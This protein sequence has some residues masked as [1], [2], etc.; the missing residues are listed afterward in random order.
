[1]NLN[2]T[3][4]VFVRAPRYVLGEITR[5]HDEIDG[6]AEFVDEARMVPDADLWGWGE[7]HQT[8]L[9][10]AELAVEAGSR[11]LAAAAVEPG[12]VDALVLC[13][14]R[15]PAEIAQHGELIAT[16]L[17]GLELGPVP[18]TGVTLNRC[19]NL[20]VGLRVAAA[21]V[22]AGQ[23]RT[24]LVITT[25]RVAEE[26]ERLTEFALFSDG[27]ASCLVTQQADTAGDSYE[28][29]ADAGALDPAALGRVTEISA[30]L[31]KVA[32]AQLC[33]E[34]GITLD[35]IDGLLHNNIYLPIVTMKEVQAGFSLSQLDTA[36]I[37][38]VGHCFA[39]DPL[40]N[41]ADRRSAGTIRPD[42]LYLLASSVSGFRVCVLLRAGESLIS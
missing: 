1:M 37:A 9:T 42:G 41:L 6:F 22:A 34:A 30:D 19:A 10:T 3:T 20:L 26:S 8:A 23:H 15:F 7:V 27:A 25:D 14:T 39:A 17:R 36:N 13:S 38:R 18:V 11:T 24:V 31:A 5:K 2:Q 21:M 35:A 32:N 16:V 40:I 28:W 33:A 4:G 12:E 29:V